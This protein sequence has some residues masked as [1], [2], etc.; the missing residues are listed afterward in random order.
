LFNFA[1]NIKLFLSRIMTPSV[2]TQNPCS[3]LLGG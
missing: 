3:R 1:K 2:L